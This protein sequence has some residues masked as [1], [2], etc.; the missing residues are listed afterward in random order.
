MSAPVSV[1][2]ELRLGVAPGFVLPPL[3][4]LAATRSL[5]VDGSTSAIEVGEPERFSSEHFDTADL[6]L[7]RRGVTLQRRQGEGT[8]WILELPRPTKSGSNKADCRLAAVDGGAASPP[9]VLLD[10]LTAYV[11]TGTLAPV[12]HLQTERVTHALRDAESRLVAQID[13]DT[14]AVYRGDVV[15]ARFR[16]LEL[17]VGPGASPELVDAL[18]DF[19]RDAGAS[20]PD[21]LPTLVRALGPRALAPAELD[22]PDLGD[23]SSAGE[24]VTSALIAATNL[25]LDHDH[26]VRLDDDTEG[27]HQ[28]RVATRRLRS[29]LRVFASLFDPHWSAPLRSDLKW[30]ARSLGRVRDRDVLIGRLRRAAGELP[31]RNDRRDA[32]ALIS[33]VAAERERAQRRLLGALRSDRYRALVDGVVLAVVSPKVTDGAEALAS[34]ALPPV[35]KKPYRTVRKAVERV[36]LDPSDDELHALRIDVKR[37]RYAAEVAVPVLGG[38]MR[39]FAKALAGFGDLLGDHHDASV[40]EDWLRAAARHA[41]AGVGD[42]TARSVALVAGELVAGQRSERRALRRELPSAWERVTLAAARAGYDGAKP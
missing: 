14:T 37:A 9:E 10:L 16:H 15:A 40:A 39:A 27:V 18:V 19:L 33:R 29:H 21:P 1:R 32:E 25:L 6:R 31:A 34:T 30:L 42:G 36:G 7:V 2:R 38:E 11:R 3:D 13:D 41:P 12:A 23:A 22:R 26:V 17:D 4:A 8:S 5:H 24:V 35:V 20:A 28:A